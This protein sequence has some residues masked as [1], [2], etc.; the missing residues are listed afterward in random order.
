MADSL[1]DE[2]LMRE[3]LEALEGL[4]GWA[5]DVMAGFRARKTPFYSESDRQLLIIPS[6][7]AIA[8]LKERLLKA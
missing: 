6:S 2:Q 5:E 4:T 1:T 7:A 3:A 8:N